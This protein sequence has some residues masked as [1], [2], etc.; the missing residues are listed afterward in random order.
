ML[1]LACLCV[2]GFLSFNGSFTKFFGVVTHVEIG[3][4][5]FLVLRDLVLLAEGLEFTFEAF[6][7]FGVLLVGKLVFHFGGVGLEVVEFPFF[8]VVEIHEFVATI[9]DTFVAVNHV[10]A[11]IFVVMIVVGGSPILGLVTFEE[12]K[13]AHAL[14]V[15]RLRGSG[16]IEEG[17]GKVE[18]GDEVLVDAAR[19]GNSMPAYE[20]RCAVGF[21]EHEPL[22]EPT[23]FT[24]VKALVTG[25]DEDGVF[26]QTFALKVLLKSPH[27]VIDG[28]DAA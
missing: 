20:K 13:E 11:W 24:E 12:R 17:L 5:L 28:A 25:V 9:V 6:D 19:A 10:P 1:L 14:H 26:S 22:V 16:D 4:V 2:L 8:D 18:I 15:R 23:V 7:D 21:V 3:E 27:T